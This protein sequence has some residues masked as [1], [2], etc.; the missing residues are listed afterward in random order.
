[1]G[2]A[3]LDPKLLVS[4]ISVYTAMNQVG[5]LILKKSAKLSLPDN[6]RSNQSHEVIVTLVR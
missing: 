3:T 1:M 4:F 2:R 5:Q 6:T